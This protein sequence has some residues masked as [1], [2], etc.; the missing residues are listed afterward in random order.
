MGR[1]TGKY[2]VQNPLPNERKFGH[3]SLTELEPIIAELKS[4]GE[5]HGGKTPA[6]VALNWCICKGT[7]PIC[8]VK[9]QKQVEDNLGA[10]GWRLTDAEVTRLDKLSRQQPK[11]MWQSDA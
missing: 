6:Q 8:G 11:S 9:N 5:A 3:I 4:I 1:L 10:L 2:N 7:V